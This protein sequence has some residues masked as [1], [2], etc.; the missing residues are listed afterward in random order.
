MKSR[1]GSRVLPGPSRFS[2]HR[3]ISGEPVSAWHTTT[4]LSPPRDSVP[5]GPVGHRRRFRATSP[6][7]SGTGHP[8]SGEDFR[9]LGFKRF[10][11]M[12]LPLRPNSNALEKSSLMS[13]MC[14][15]PTDTRMRSDPTPAANLSASVSCRWVVLAGWITSVLA[16]PTLARW[17][18]S[19]TPP[20]KAQ[21]A[22]APPRMPKVRTQPKPFVEVAR[23]TFVG[24][25]ISRGPGRTPNRRPA[26]RPTNGPAPERCRLAVGP[27]GKASPGPGGGGRR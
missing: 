23:R 11:H 9:R 17:L 6:H 14:S 22:S 27:A 4:A 8:G 2:H 19:S 15:N 1:V 10:V 12:V 26:V 20:M 7:S 21:P 18:A 3:S 13:S 24:W 16:S 25:M 5:H